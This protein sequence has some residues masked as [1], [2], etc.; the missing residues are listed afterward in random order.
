MAARGSEAFP[1][2]RRLRK[3]AEYLS[4]QGGGRKLHGESFLLFVLPRAEAQ[5]RIGVTVSKRVGG[6]VTRNRVKRLVR[7][8][9]RRHAAWFPMGIDL[10]FVAKPSAAALDFPRTEREVEKLCRRSLAS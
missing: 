3:R 6:A 8:V 10:V 7:E 5:T 9:V 4:V 2:C 1:R